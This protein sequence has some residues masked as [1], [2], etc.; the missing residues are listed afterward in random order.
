MKKEEIDIWLLNKIKSCYIVSNV[1]YNSNHLYLYHDKSYIR[2]KKLCKIGEK[3]P[4]PPNINNGIC[5]FY[6]DI[7]YKILYCNYDDIWLHAT[8]TKNISNLSTVF[9]NSLNR[10]KLYDYAITWFDHGINKKELLFKSSDIG[11][12]LEYRYEQIM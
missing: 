5:L 6:L 9:N 4:L 12:I 2:Y 3:E 7:K 10:T 1:N 8:E 11:S